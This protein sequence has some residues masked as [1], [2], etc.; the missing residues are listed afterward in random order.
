[1]SVLHLRDINT[2]V[3]N[4]VISLCHFCE[5]HGPSVLFVTQAFHEHHSPGT[6]TDI[7]QPKFCY[8]NAAGRSGTVSNNMPMSCE[9]CI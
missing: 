4:A 1:M 2:N 8:G 9:V 3:M 5:L 7:Q 6:E